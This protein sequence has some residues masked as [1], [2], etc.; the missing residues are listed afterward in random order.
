MTGTR[1]CKCCLRLRPVALEHGGHCYCSAD[2]A[3]AWGEDQR[4]V[5]LLAAAK[6][7]RAVEACAAA[8]GHLA[9]AARAI[10][11]GSRS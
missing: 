8:R 1:R 10:A 5:G 2:C 9:D 6:A 7:L 4:N 11:A 3:Q